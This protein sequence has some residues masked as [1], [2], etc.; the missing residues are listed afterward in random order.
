[1]KRSLFTILFG[2]CLTFSA[3]AATILWGTEGDFVGENG[4]AMASGSAFLYLVDTSVGYNI[5]ASDG[6]WFISG[7]TLVATG[8]ITG[9]NTYIEFESTVDYSTQYKPNNN[10]QGTNFYV[11]VV[12]TKTGNSLNDITDGF[13]YLTD[14]AALFNN[15]YPGGDG[16]TVEDSSGDIFFTDDGSSGWQPVPEPTA[17]AL[18]ALGVAG[19]ALRRRVR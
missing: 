12:T 8:N 13:Y 4:S 2:V 6:V 9:E 11:M 14:P 15:G 1:M 5:S 19:V 10:G 17:L 7:A 18:L 3:S 16:V